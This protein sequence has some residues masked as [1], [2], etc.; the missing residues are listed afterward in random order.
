VDTPSPSTT[1][2]GSIWEP[3]FWIV[4]FWDNQILFPVYFFV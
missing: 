2:R 3:K 4:T 1:F